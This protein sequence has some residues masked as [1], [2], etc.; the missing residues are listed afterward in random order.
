MGKKTKKVGRKDREIRGS[1]W[2]R[3]S[4]KRIERMEG[5]KL[6]MKEYK[7]IPQNQRT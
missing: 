6:Y 4:G 5:K 7:K 2:D 1:M 3:N